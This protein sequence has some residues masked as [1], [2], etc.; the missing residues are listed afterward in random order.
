V[1]PDELAKAKNYIALRFPRRFETTGNIATQLGE[2]FVYD[3]PDT[4][5]A[6]F[7]DRI[8]AVTAADVQRV[9]KTLVQPSRLAVVVVGDRKVIEAPVRALKLGPM[10]FM[11]V[12]EA[13][14]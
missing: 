1:P 8:Q 4:Y 9:A 13:I 14:P 11:K 2:V 7:V 5:F 3:L 6:T 12:E 10:S